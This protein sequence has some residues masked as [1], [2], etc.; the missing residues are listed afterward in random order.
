MISQMHIKK[1][2]DMRVIFIGILL[3]NVVHVQGGLGNADVLTDLIWKL[4]GLIYL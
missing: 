3:L 4:S 2:G 1:E